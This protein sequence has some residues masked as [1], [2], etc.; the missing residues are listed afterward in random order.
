MSEKANSEL[1]M[2]ERPRS[3]RPSY[4]KSAIAFVFSLLFFG[5]LLHPVP[6]SYH[7]AC[8]AYSQLRPNTV[9]ER[10][11]K[12]LSKTPL[13]GMGL[14]ASA[15][16]SCET[17]NVYYSDGHDDFP[18]LVRAL[19]GGHIY[20]DSF[21]TPFEEGGLRQHVDLPRLRSGQNGG[22]FWSVFAPCP[23]NG[24]DWSDENYSSSKCLSINP[25]DAPSVH[26]LLKVLNCR[27][28]LPQAWCSPSSKLT[29]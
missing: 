27:L 4:S 19:Y 20:Q 18:I 7:P 16:T 28:T 23:A 26:V 1:P 11:H 17:D 14:R 21:K 2:T 24:S 13:I 25:F 8:H 12:I 3:S 29:L 10:V 9:E 5:S 22:A 6:R 15:H